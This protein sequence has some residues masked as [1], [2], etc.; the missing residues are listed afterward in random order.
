MK[1]IFDIMMVISL[2]ILVVLIFLLFKN[3]LFYKENQHTILKS[4]KSNLFI[5]KACAQNPE[6]N[7]GYQASNVVSF[8]ESDSYKPNLDNNF[9]IKECDSHNT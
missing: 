3:T 6:G 2:L 4:L 8:L 5:I 7:S 9:V 1:I